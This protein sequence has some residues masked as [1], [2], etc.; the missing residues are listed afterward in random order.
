MG[1][2]SGEP[3]FP[4]QGRFMP[5]PHRPRFA[6]WSAPWQTNALPLNASCSSLRKSG[7]GG[8]KDGGGDRKGR[9]FGLKWFFLVVI[10]IWGEDF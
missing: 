8:A 4:L 9:G 6:T 7:Q 2:T 10:P 3:P 5:P 1:Y